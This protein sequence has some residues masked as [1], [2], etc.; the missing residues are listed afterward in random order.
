MSCVL[1]IGLQCLSYLEKRWDGPN[2]TD[3]FRVGL[4]TGE[5]YNTQRFQNI[6]G[7]RT[8]TTV[9]SKQFEE[10]QWVKAE[11]R[12]RAVLRSAEE[13][14]LWEGSALEPGQHLGLRHPLIPESSG[15]DVSGTS[16]LKPLPPTCST[17]PDPSLGTNNSPQQ[18]KQQGKLPCLETPSLGQENI[19]HMPKTRPSGVKMRPQP[20]SQRGAS[21]T[22]LSLWLQEA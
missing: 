2:Y 12:V 17:T 5:E 20:A 10:C 11:M 3:F 7:Q 15:R 6:I 19:F 14:G 4:F 1:S 16:R 21:H 18:K 22:L 13:Q 8:L 9:S